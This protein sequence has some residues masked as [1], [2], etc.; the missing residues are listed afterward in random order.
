MLTSEKVSCHLVCL[1]AIT[2]Q[3]EQGPKEI[4]EKQKTNK[5]KKDMSSC[6]DIL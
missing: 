2:K 6:Q 4:Y 1:H 5:R 3:R